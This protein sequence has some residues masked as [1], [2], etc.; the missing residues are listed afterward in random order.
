MPAGL[1]IH[2][3]MRG[4][5][6]QAAGNGHS[7]WNANTKPYPESGGDSALVRRKTKMGWAAHWRRTRTS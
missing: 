5:P 1:F 6:P 4:S 3:L 2:A 7:N